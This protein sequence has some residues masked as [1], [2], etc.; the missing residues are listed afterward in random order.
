M[1]RRSEA[2]A[3]LAVREGLLGLVCVWF[4]WWCYCSVVL[5]VFSVLFNVDAVVVVSAAAIAVVV[6]FDLCFL[7]LATDPGL[8]RGRWRRLSCTCWG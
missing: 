8:E 4:W 6:C 5:V 2:A 3:V 1:R 7:L